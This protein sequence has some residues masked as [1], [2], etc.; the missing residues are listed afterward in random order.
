V[1]AT[2]EQQAAA[3]GLVEV[4]D[5]EFAELAYPV[6]RTYVS[7]HAD[8]PSADQLDIH[9]TDGHGVQ[10]PR[11]SVLLRRLLPEFK[12]RYQS[13]LEAEHIA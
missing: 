5:A 4:E 8:F 10:H 9:L 13:E 3:T 1:D 11:S 12:N 7:Q 2:P 6:F